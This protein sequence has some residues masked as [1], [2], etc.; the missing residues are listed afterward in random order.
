MTRAAKCLETFQYPGKGAGQHDR[1]PAS[2]GINK[3]QGG[4]IEQG[5]LLGHHVRQDRRQDR[6]ST[7]RGHQPG[8][9]A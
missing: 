3:K 6:S 9:Q 2:Q 8:D 1:R 5:P 7:L 4:P